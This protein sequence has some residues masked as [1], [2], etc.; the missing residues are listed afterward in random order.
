MYSLHLQAEGGPQGGL[1]RPTRLDISL[2][3]EDTNTALRTDRGVEEHSRPGTPHTRSPGA[4][5]SGLRRSG[6]WDT[7]LGRP[8]SWVLFP[9]HP[10]TRWSLKMGVQQSKGSWGSTA[11]SLLSP[12]LLPWPPPDWASCH[13]TKPIPPSL[14]GPS[15]SPFFLLLST[16]SFPLTLSPFLR[17][18]PSPTPSAL[19]SKFLS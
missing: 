5:W 4:P 9:A 13:R 2:D 3:L 6:V 10:P 8:G 14:L 1:G 15:K 16:F 18:L 7:V 17:L 19:K 11:L 12:Y